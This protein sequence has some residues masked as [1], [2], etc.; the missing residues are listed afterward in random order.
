MT[1]PHPPSADSPND[2]MPPQTGW[3]QSLAWLPNAISIGRIILTIPIIWLLLTQRYETALWLVFIAGISDGLDGFLAKRFHWTSRLGGILDPIADKILLI[4]AFAILA[5][6]AHMFWWVAAIV[7]LRDVGLLLT[8]TYY[9]FR[10]RKLV[11][12]PSVV[13]KI[14]TVLQIALA[15]LILVALAG[16]FSLPYD[17]MLGISVAVFVSTLLSGLDYLWNWGQ[18]AI[19]E[20]RQN[21]N[22]QQHRSPTHH[23]CNTHNNGKSP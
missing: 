15:L 2:H 5:W 7:L 6:Q 14:N 18:K 13:S 8:G 21:K 12:R 1:E 11:A 20:D 4:S 22:H 9:H 10:I 16:W 23:N 19:R 17:W 3:R